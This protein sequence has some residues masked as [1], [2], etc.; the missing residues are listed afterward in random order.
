[1]GDVWVNNLKGKSMRL[2]LTVLLL[3]LGLVAAA[4]GG[5]G[6]ASTGVASLETADV[7]VDDVG[8]L[9]GAEPSSESDQEQA[10]LNFAACMRDNGVDI[11]DPT[12]DADGNVQFGGFRVAVQEGEIDRVA[13]D[14]AMAECQE[15]LESITLGRGGGDFDPTEL[16]DTMVEYA[17]C[18]RENGYDM[19]D[20]DFSSFGP[21]AGGEPGQGGGGPFGSIDFNDPDFVS[22]Q[23]AC[24]DILGSF[25]APG[26]GGARRAAGSTG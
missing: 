12:V 15:H 11:D 23:E 16:Q 5:D 3:A 4:C 24:E 2:R 20:P 14:A 13:M 9:D 26:E 21:G 6:D 8:T 17:A 7:A 22:A 18:M 25:R 19:P 1:M 10:M